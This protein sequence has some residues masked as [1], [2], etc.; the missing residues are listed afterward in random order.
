MLNSA[1]QSKLRVAVEA[2]LTYMVQERV[3]QL[4]VSH[5]DL[6]KLANLGNARIGRLREDVDMY[7]LKDPNTEAIFG[8]YMVVDH[9]IKDGEYFMCFAKQQKLLNTLIVD[10]VSGKFGR[11]RVFADSMAT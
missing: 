10:P 6:H 4:K 1:D 2:V 11:A 5:R 8:P 3:Q 7:V 9:S